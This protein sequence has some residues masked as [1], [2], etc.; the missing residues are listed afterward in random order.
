MPC[1]Y[2]A[3]CLYRNT[4]LCKTG[5]CRSQFIHPVDAVGV[6]CCVKIHYQV[7]LKSEHW[8]VYALC[9]CYENTI[10]FPL[11]AGKQADRRCSDRDLLVNQHSV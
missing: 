1:P 5:L 4:S 8:P 10:S 11:D 9:R 7:F 2:F 6:Q 3:E